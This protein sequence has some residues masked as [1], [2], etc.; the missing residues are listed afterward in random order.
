MTPEMEAALVSVTTWV[1]TG[2]LRWISPGF[3]H[4]L[5]K[6][7]FR[8]AIVAVVAVCIAVVT[9]LAQGLAWTGVVRLAITALAG[10][11][12]LRQATK[13]DK[14]TYNTESLGRTNRVDIRT[15]L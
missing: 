5:D 4:D 3:W 9:G 13:G 7:I 14:L 1:A 10:S 8:L 11:V 2:L 12:L 6:R 15:K